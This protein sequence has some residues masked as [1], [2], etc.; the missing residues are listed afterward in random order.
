MPELPEVET[1]RLALEP[2][3]V[4]RTFRRVAI[5]DTRLTMPESPGAVAAELAG[6]R[7]AAVE[8]RGKYLVLR[9]DSGLALVVH[10]R[11]TGGF[12]DEPASHE[13]A[14]VELD[15]GGT[16][17][18]RDVRRFGTWHLLGP[19]ELGKYL[20]TRLGP[21]PLGP[22]FTAAHL[23]GRLAGRRAPLKPALLDQRTVAGMGNIY[24][25]EALWHARLH[26]LRP[27]G[28]LS[29]AE[30]AALRRGVRHALRRGIARQGADLG[31]G[32]YPAGAMQEEFRVY[33]RELEPCSRC[34]TPIEKTW[35]AGRGTH[36]CPGCQC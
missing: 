5:H 29:A 1:Y 4:G 2:R 13:R 23:A 16:V 34:G 7:V 30:V 20:D 17:V 35:V 36:Y 28:S 15:D 8:R 3:L 11:M 10:L 32:A 22:R 25:D 6:E 33:G 14:V 19:E 9:F 26:P 24:A 21:E 27:A 31:D 18:Y 12:P